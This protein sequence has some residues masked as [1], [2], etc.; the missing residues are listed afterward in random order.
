M[1]GDGAPAPSAASEPGAKGEGRFRPS[2]VGRGSRAS[3]PRSMTGDPRRPRGRGRSCPFSYGGSNG[4]SRRTRPTRGSSTGSAPRG[5]RARSARRRRGRAAPG[6]YGKMPGI[7]YQ[8]YA[9]ARAHRPLGRQPVGLRDPPGPVHPGGAEARGAQ[10]RGRRPAP[11]AAGRAR[12]PSPRASARARDLR[13]RP[14]RDPLAL[15]RR[16]G[17]PEVPR[18]A[19]HGRR[20]AASGAPRRGRS[21]APRPRRGSRPQDIE[22]L[23]AP[24]RRIHPGGPA[25]RLGPG[26]QPQRRLGDGR[27]PRA[28]GGGRASSA[29]G[30]AAT[31][32]PTRAPGGTSTDRQAPRLPEPSTRLINMN[33]LGDALAA[34]GQ[35]SVDLLFVYNANPLMT[36]PAQEKVR[37]GLERED[38]FTVVFDP[39]MTDT[40]R[41]ADVVLPAATFLERTRDLARLRGPRAPGRRRRSCR[42][43]AR[44]GRTTRSSRT[45]AGA[46][47]WRGP[48]IR[49]RRKR[50]PARSRLEPARTGAPGGARPRRRRHALGGRRRRSSSWTPFRSTS[51]RQDPPRARGPRP[52]RRPEASIAI[53]PIRA[54]G[55]FPAR[56]DLAGDGPDDQLDAG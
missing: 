6:L 39:V 13:A 28:A 16:K 1:Y 18:R 19:R 37:A 27:D 21:S 35:D 8:D 5:W 22:R 42:P 7:A 9:H 24:L 38:L 53:G 26:A 45:S 25:L 12:R 17:R 36:I 4:Y 2:L 34:T 31:R 32:C 49:S 14:R 51:D 55:A 50:S 40:A 48:G 30:A 10:A 15:R 20:G 46:P 11:Y 52:R 43:R 44:R 29:C 41:Y 33:L 47:A 56:P 23:R 54:A 3:W